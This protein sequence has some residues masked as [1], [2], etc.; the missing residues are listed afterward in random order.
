MKIYAQIADQ[1]IEFIKKNNGNGYA[2][3]LNNSDIVYDL[4]NLG[5]N[6]YSLIWDNRSYLLYF[7]PKDDKI[8]VSL[9]GGE[10]DVH[11][12]T[13][14]ER[15]IREMTAGREYEQRDMILK[16]PIP[17][18]V[19]KILVNADDHVQKEYPMLILEAMKMENIIKAPCSCQ[20]SQIMVKT[21]QSVEQDAPLLKL[22]S[23]NN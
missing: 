9:D 12:E 13:E 21:G 17:G 6:R 15:R 4:E 20:V 8:I 11:I 3:A 22:K 1:T 23:S 10:Y 16:A 7:S 14:R 19:S 2:L 18:L 5:G